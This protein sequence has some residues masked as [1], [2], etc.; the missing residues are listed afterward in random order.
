MSFVKLDCGILNSTLWVE[1][2]QRDLFITALLMAEPREFLEP[3]PQ[4]RAGDGCIEET[5]FVVPPGWYGFVPASGPGIVRMALTPLDEG[6]AALAVL[7]EPDPE[8]RSHDFDGRRLVRVNGGYIVLNYMAYREKDAT[9]A[10]RSRRW[11]LRQ[12]E[13]EQQHETTRS[14]AVAETPQR[15]IRHQEEVEAEAEKNNHPLTP[16]NAG[17]GKGRKTKAKV[18]FPTFVKSC[19][20]AREK[21]IPV[22]D[23]IFTFAEDVGIPKEYL[24]LAWREFARKHRASGRM[25]KD[26]RAHFRDAVRRNWFKLWWFPAEGQCDLT[27]AGVQMKRERD[28]DRAHEAER[29]A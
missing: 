20:D 6:L 12:K 1:R 8:S 7:G 11:R 22:G 3:M 23:P 24:E 28:A 10:D 4:L 5:G 9:A 19:H 15:V 25:Q 14:N 29:A 16:A 13:K 17:E 27:T 21:P 18:T 2:G 26:W